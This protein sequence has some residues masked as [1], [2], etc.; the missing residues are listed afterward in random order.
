MELLAKIK[1]VSENDASSQNLMKL[2]LLN[3]SAYDDVFD[4]YSTIKNP[5][6]K[7][8]LALLM[9]N[10]NNEQSKQVLLTLLKDKHSL[11]QG[12]AVRQLSKNSSNEVGAVL[13]QQLKNA[14]P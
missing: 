4:K 7:F 5:S 11:V 12:E 3:Y 14:N 6:S 10:I 9:G 8:A 1:P 13:L 2:Y